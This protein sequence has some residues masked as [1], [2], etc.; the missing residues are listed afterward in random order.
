MKIFAVRD[1]YDDSRKSLAYLIYYE[2]A[3]RFYI[4]IPE[5]AD[6]WETPLLLESFVKRGERSINA[7][8][9]R[10]WV[11]QRIVPTD[12]QNLGQILKENGLESYDEFE[13]LML[14]K[15]RCAQDDYYLE[16]VTQVDFL[17]EFVQRYQK[18]VEDVI[19]LEN[20]QLLIFFQN[21][22]VKKCDMYKLLAHERRFQPVLKNTQLFCSVGMQP[23]GYG[24]SWGEGLD[25]ADRQL[26]DSGGSISLKMEDFIRFIF[27][28]VISTSEAAEILECS[29]QNI[30]DLVRRGKLHPIKELSQNKLFLKSEIMQRKW[31]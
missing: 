1:E 12:R 28:R 4:E 15:G 7:Y 2:K 8:W 24:I 26:Y 21:G 5:E 25:V 17:R 14:G 6:S 23:G 27:H 30:D 16:P 10:M 19:P 29:R 13:L 3:K 9:S 18:K 20:G 22:E 31:G 11:Q